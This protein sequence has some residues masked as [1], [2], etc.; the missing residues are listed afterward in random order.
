MNKDTQE[1]LIALVLALCL[2]FIGFKAID[3]WLF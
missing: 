3:A 1:L 2:M